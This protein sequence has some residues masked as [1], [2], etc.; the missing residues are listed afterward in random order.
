MRKPDDWIDAMCHEWA[1]QVI[2][3]FGNA[4]EL[5]KDQLGSVRSI[6]GRVKQYSDGS[7]GTTQNQYFP[8]FM[9]GDALKVWR[10]TKALND[11]QRE[12]L[13]WHYV[14]RWYGWNPEGT[15]LRRKRWP[16]KVQA[17]CQRMGID[18]DTYFD[19]VGVAKDALTPELV[20]ITPCDNGV[21][22]V[23]FGAQS[24]LCA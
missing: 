6:L 19:R 2:Q 8:S 17:L 5:G 11:S 13:R 20:E 15:K 12:I 18:R 22:L 3:H 10:A 7:A 24:A 9:T 4:P 21:D 23:T 14:V 16:T 1:K